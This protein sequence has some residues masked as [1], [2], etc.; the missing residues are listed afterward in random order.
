MVKEESEEISASG[1]AI[2]IA[3]AIFAGFTELARAIDRLSAAVR[4][5]GSEDELEPESLGTYLDGTKIL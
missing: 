4:Q 5:D 3:D 2:V 1:D